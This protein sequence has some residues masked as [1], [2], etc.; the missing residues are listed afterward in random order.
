M[1]ALQAG[2]QRSPKDCTISTLI[3][4]TEVVRGE[5]AGGG[6]PGPEMLNRANK[7]QGYLATP[8]SEGE[9]DLLFQTV[10]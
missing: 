5:G 6:A 1:E 8:G 7:Y 9:A 2:G 3:C 10:S 4:F